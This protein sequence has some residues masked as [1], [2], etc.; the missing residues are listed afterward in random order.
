MRIQKWPSRSAALADFVAA[1]LTEFPHSKQ[2][3]RVCLPE[4]EKTSQS[5]DRAGGP[6]CTKNST[7]GGPH[8]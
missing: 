4:T 7:A 1:K 8:L 3:R 5:Q 6:G 2:S